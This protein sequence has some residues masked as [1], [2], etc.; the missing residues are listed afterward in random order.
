MKITGETKIVGVVGYPISH[1]LSP[2]LHNAAFEHSGL[3][4]VYI[5]LLVRPKDLEA[6]I[7]AV[8]SLN[9]TGVNITVP[10][11]EKVMAHLNEISPEARSIGAVNT[12]YN[13]DGRL[14]GYNTDEEG[15][16]RSLT[17]EGRF[18]PKGKN[19]LLLGAGGAARAISFALIRAGVRKLT[20]ANRTERRAKNLLGY[21]RKIFKDKCE[22]Y[23]LEFCRRNSPEVAKEVDLL[24]NA[25]SIG[26]HPEDPLPIELELFTKNTFIYDIVY[27][28]E[29][30]LLREA[31]KRGMPFM[32]GLE[33]L[34]SQGALSFEIW[35]HQK[36]P[37]RIMRKA[38]K[39]R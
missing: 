35:T 30:E 4:F 34:I 9:I 15:F 26:M 31:R 39:E 20:V 32:G 12:V 37:I 3:N 1:S 27:N 28:R 25:T 2:I 29:T 19:I 13:E 17:R 22:L 21:L 23:F 16:I 11:K 36:A 33:M 6:V 14:I 5:P 10:F 24:V 18:D 8:R 38:L 7:K